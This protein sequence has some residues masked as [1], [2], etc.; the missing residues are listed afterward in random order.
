[1]EPELRALM[2]SSEFQAYHRQSSSP[3]FSPFDVLQVADSEIRHSNVLA[4]LLRP[5]ETHGIGGRFLRAFVDHLRERYDAESLRRLSGLDDKNDVE[6]RREDYHEGG[7]ADITICFRPSRH[8]PARVESERVL[9]VI[10]NKVVGW[11]PEAERQLQGY[12]KTFGEKYKVRYDNCYGVLLTTSSS[13]EKSGGGRH[14]GDGSFR[15]SWDDVRGL[16]VGS[17]LTDGESGSFSDAHVRAFVE[18]YVEVI[19][20]KLIHAGDDLAER[21]RSN[22]SPILRRLQADPAILDEVDGPRRATIRRW[23]EYFGERPSTLRETVAEYLRSK[24]RVVGVKKSAGRGAWKRDRWLYWEAPSGG[25]PR[26][27]YCVWCIVC[28]PRNVTVELWERGGRRAR[29]SRGSGAF[30]RTRL[31]IRPGRRDTRWKTGSSIAMSS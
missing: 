31:S 26:I 20:E 29:T 7:Y 27:D 1:M 12:L 11:S 18:R 23:M 5:D 13:L 19:G 22:H 3:A 28:R 10:E 24:Q 14:P 30:C 6:I 8:D 25:A 17:L 2:D 4:W 15:L 21:L 16:I 9:L